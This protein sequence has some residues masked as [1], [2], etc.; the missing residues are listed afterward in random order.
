MRA[1]RNHDK[2]LLSQMTWSETHF[3]KTI[4]ISYYVENIQKNQGQDEKQ[5]N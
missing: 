3:K 1:A 4:M 2:I 5:E